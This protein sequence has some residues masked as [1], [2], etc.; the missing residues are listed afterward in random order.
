MILTYIMGHTLTIV[1]STLPDVL[2]RLR[3]ASP[4]PGCAQTP[5][6]SPRLANRQLKFYFANLRC[7]VFDDILRWQQATLHGSA[8]KDLTWLPVF[9]VMLGFAMVLEELQCTLQI[10]ADAKAEKGEMARDAAQAQAKNACESIDERYDFLT[11]LFR[12]K[13]RS[14]KWTR[15]GSFGNQTPYLTSDAEL[16]FLTRLWVLVDSRRTSSILS[17]SCLYVADQNHRG[18]STAKEGCATWP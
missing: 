13:Y 5:H 8:S 17:L 14:S 6:I 16:L 12:A 2:L 3:H 18:A 7:K 10:Q 9:C 15:R 4:P 11:Q 1:D